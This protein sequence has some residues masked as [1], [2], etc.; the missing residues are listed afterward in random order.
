M[1]GAVFR[2][3][4]YNVST[5]ADVPKSLFFG[6]PTTLAA[7]TL[8]MWYLAL[9]KY[10]NAGHIISVEPFGGARLFPFF[11]TPEAIWRYLPLFLFGGGILMGSNLRIPKLGNMGSRLFTAFVF[12]NVL[13]G[14]VLAPA[15][16]YPEYLIWPPTAWIIVFTIWGQVSE[17]A[18]SLK[19]PPIFPHVPVEPVEEEALF[20]TNEDEP[21]TLSESP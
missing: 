4:R 19:A 11:E 15:R 6:I 3:A 8:T 9:L 1:L 10:T 20:E 13:L 16:L 14:M 2:L 12:A 21:T 18:R 7:G 5:A 17:K